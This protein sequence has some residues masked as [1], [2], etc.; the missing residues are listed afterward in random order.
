MKW[1]LEALQKEALKYHFRKDFENG[2]VGAYSS[3]VKRGYINSICSHMPYKRRKHTYKSLHKAALKYTT[4]KQFELNDKSAFNMAMRKGYLKD[5]CSH[6]T[7]NLQPSDTFYIWKAVD[8]KYNDQPIYKIGVTR[9]EYGEHR[10]QAVANKHGFTKEVIIFQKLTN[11]FETEKS[12]LNKYASQ[13]VKTLG[14]IDGHSEFRYLSEI[15]LEDILNT[16]ERERCLTQI[17]PM[18][19]A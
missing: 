1:T 10:L 6:M 11:V 15:D 8:E 7:I 18:A 19:I 5:V 12:I 4:K 2:S 17:Q 14:K 9:Y 16:I 3:A 13:R